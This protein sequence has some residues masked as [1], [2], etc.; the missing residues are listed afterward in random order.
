MKTFMK[1]NCWLTGV[2]IVVGLG[3]LL[4]LATT[5]SAAEKKHGQLSV[6]DYKFACAAASGGATEVTLGKIAAEKAVSPDVKAFGERMVT[7]HGKAGDK[8][9][10]IAS[11]QGAVLPDQ[12][13]AMEQ[14]TIDHLNSLSGSAF[15]KEYVSAMVK[16]HQ[17]DLKEFQEEA[18]KAENGELKSFAAETA[19]VVE[20]HLKM[21]QDL[22][23]QL[24]QKAEK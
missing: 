14:K 18:A 17:K 20:S 7:D 10:S 11:E 22:Q 15:D 3:T 24:S 1:S 8:L 21:A 12:P 19:Q 16:D 6:S 2:N 5:A 9:K 23:N 13:T 4:I